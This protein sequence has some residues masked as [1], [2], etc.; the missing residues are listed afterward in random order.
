M[1]FRGLRP[2]VSFEDLAPWVAGLVNGAELGTVGQ[3]RVFS[4]ATQ[5]SLNVEDG[6]RN[7]THRSEAA[8]RVGDLFDG[9]VSGIL[10]ALGD[11]TSA[12]LVIVGPAG[13]G[14]RAV[15]DQAFGSVD[16]QPP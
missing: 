7:G 5:E 4:K 1:Q 2:S 15:F 3:V 9:P 16:P 12:G 6:K 11:P 14:R 8:T 13:S 10:N